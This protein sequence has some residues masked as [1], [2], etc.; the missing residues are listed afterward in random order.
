M[1]LGY[2]LILSCLKSSSL[3]SIQVLI[4]Q[5]SLLFHTRFKDVSVYKYTEQDFPCQ[6]E[7]KPCSNIT[8]FVQYQR[9]PRP[10]IHNNPSTKT[11][12]PRPPVAQIPYHPD[13]PL[14]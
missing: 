2:N 13:P 3:C 1:K 7:G 9:K 6:I 11:L 14:H 10:P 4:L 8:A 12:A 5:I